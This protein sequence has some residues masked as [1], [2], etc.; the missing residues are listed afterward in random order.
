MVPALC[1]D[2]GICVTAYT[3]H[4]EAV[5]NEGGNGSTGRFVSAVLKPRVTIAAGNDR[6]K[7][8]NCI[9]KHTA[10]VFIANSVNF[11]IECRAESESE[12]VV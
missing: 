7:A 5:M 3:D 8:L 9:T 12:E 2:A 11:P 10:C 1:A 4:A 6:A